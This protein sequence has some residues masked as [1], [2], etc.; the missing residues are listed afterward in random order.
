MSGVQGGGGHRP[1]RR[2]PIRLVVP[3][4]PS[5][6]PC[7][8]V[9]L[10]KSTSSCTLRGPPSIFPLTQKFL[11]NRSDTKHI[12]GALRNRRA[13]IGAFTARSNIIFFPLGYHGRQNMAVVRPAPAAAAAPRP[14]AAKWSSLS[15]VGACRALSGARTGSPHRNLL[16]FVLR[17]VCRGWWQQRWHSHH[18]PP[19][20]QPHRIIRPR[21]YLGNV[22]CPLFELLDR[23]RCRNRGPLAS[24]LWGSTTRCRSSPASLSQAQAAIALTLAQPRCISF[25][26]LPFLSDGF[27]V[28][29]PPAQRERHTDPGSMVHSVNRQWLQAKAARCA[30]LLRSSTPNLRHRARRSPPLR[31][32]QGL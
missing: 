21:F 32:R 17:T 5:S 10:S 7:L 4:P 18:R 22:T 13:R 9:I 1:P 6:F 25:A 27:D 15:P 30:P 8:L 14:G 29:S 19:H 24:G 16:N 23:S 3:P 28:P 12:C 31:A 2:R 20:R 11:Q 26:L